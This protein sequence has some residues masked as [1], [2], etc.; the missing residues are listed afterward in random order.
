M[1]WL[2]LACNGGAV[3]PTDDSPVDSEDTHTETG[4]TSPDTSDTDTDPPEDTSVEFAGP[5]RVIL[6]IGDGMGPEHIAGGGLYANGEAGTLRMES[7]P[8]QGRLRTASLDGLT[9]SAASGTALS[10]GVK[11]T[12]GRLGMTREGDVVQNALELASGLGLST[13]V[14]T[15]DNLW[16]ATPSSFLV[17][18]PSR[19]DGGAISRAIALALPDLLF[20]GGGGLL[21]PELETLDIQGLATRGVI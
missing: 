20:G 17:H 7:L 19:Y 15:T 11:T 10:T 18:E 4:D 5:P 12:N 6:F 2:L 1:I 14:I 13:G 21:A 16:G 3:T 9:D 8:V